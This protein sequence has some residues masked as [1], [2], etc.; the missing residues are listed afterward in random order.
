LEYEVKSGNLTRRIYSHPSNRTRSEKQQQYIGCNA[1]F[2]YSANKGKKGK[3]KVKGE[4][5]QFV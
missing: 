5:R 1:L 3:S 4:G 2:E